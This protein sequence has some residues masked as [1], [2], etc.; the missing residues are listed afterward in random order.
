M[1]ESIFVIRMEPGMVLR[2]LGSGGTPL[3]GAMSGRKSCQGHRFVVQEERCEVTAGSRGLGRLLHAEAQR[4][5]R[6][7][8]PWKPQ[9]EEP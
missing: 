7:H 3:E 5:S 2:G 1:L 9:E 4:E 6:P 8:W